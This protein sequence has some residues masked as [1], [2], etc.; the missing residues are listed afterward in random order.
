MNGLSAAL[1][2]ATN[3]NSASSRRGAPQVREGADRVVEEHH[4]EARDD[5]VEGRG[6]ERVG[7]RVGADEAWPACS[8]VSARARA[9][10]EH[11]LRNVDADAA[12][13]GAE[14]P[15][16]GERGAARAAADVEHPA[17][18]C[19]GNRCDEQVFERLEHP[20][21]QRPV[22]RPSRVRRC[23][24]KS[25]ACSSLACRVAFIVVSFACASSGG[26]SSM[27]L[28]VDLRSSG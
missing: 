23:R 10:G 11:R 18:A 2:Q 12:A 15:R 5:H 21:E 20:V 7:L 25:F 22:R 16:D 9:S 8:P 27:Q 14:Q 4:A 26:S 19:G 3:R 13:L 6:L 17:A 1:R 28:Q 24:S